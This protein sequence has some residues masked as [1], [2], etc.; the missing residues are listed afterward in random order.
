MMV[1]MSMTQATVDHAPIWRA[2]RAEAI[3][4]VAQQSAAPRPPMIA[5]TSA[6]S[7]ALVRS[8]FT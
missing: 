5:S 6:Q 4:A 7:D 2:L 8:Q 1:P 3:D